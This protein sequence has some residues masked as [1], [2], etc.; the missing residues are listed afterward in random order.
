MT[1]IGT[2][3]RISSWRRALWA[4]QQKKIVQINKEKPSINEK[5]L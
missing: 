2:Y 1:D 5:N 4:T 3:Y